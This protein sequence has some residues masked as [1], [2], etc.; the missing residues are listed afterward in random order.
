MGGDSNL[1]GE[2]CQRIVSTPMS[3]YESAPFCQKTMSCSGRVAATFSYNTKARRAAN[4]FGLPYPS[5]FAR[6]KKTFFA[7]GDDSTFLVNQLA[8][9]SGSTRLFEDCGLVSFDEGELEPYLRAPTATCCG[10]NDERRCVEA[11]GTWSRLSSTA[12]GS[13]WREGESYEHVRPMTVTAIDTANV[14]V[15]VINSSRDALGPQ[16]PSLNRAKFGS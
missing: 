11:L 5:A 10:R 13:I 15:Q 7:A 8:C 1:F 6:P 16:P 4:C 9:C 14:T 2:I 12:R 3:R